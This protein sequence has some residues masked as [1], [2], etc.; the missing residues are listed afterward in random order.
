MS[1]PFIKQILLYTIVVLHYIHHIQMACL[2]KWGGGG[3]C[4]KSEKRITVPAHQVTNFHIFCLKPVAVDYT[5]VLFIYTFCFAEHILINWT[6]IL[7]TVNSHCCEHT[8]FPNAV[9]RHVPNCCR[10]S[11]ISYASFSKGLSP[12]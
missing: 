8:K 7:A 6:C 10:Y 11:C 3:G 5:A 4:Q 12:S 2:I 1:P 9:Y